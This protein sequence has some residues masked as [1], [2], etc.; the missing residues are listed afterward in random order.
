MSQPDDLSQ[1][2]AEIL[3]RFPG[4]VTLH[5]ANLKWTL[6]SIV[7]ILVGPLGASELWLFVTEGGW[8]QLFSAGVFLYVGFFGIRAAIA[9]VTGSMWLKL[10]AEGFEFQ[11]PGHNLRREWQDVAEFSIWPTTYWTFV[12]FADRIPAKWWPP[13]LWDL[14]RILAFGDRS[15]LHDTYGLRA[16]DLAD[17]LNAWRAAALRK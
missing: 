17:L 10:D 12:T 8:F 6:I 9:L 14:N 16:K 1:K 4:P 13:K 7:L 3:G 15:W 11:F 2:A 5:P